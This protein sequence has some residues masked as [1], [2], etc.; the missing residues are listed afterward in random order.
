MP[1]LR[2]T[3]RPARTA[4]LY[5]LGSAFVLF[6][7]LYRLGDSPKLLHTSELQAKAAAK[8]SNVETNVLFAPWKLLENALLHL[9]HSVLAARLTSVIFGIICLAAFYYAMRAWLGSAIAALTTA[10]FLTTPVFLLSARHAT[11]AIMFFWPAVLIALYFYASRAE[12]GKSLVLLVA[13][14]CIGLYVPGLVWIAILGLIFGWRGLLERSREM[15]RKT[16]LLG[17]LLAII[18]LAPLIAGM[19]IH[20]HLIKPYLLLP[21]HF[22]HPL[23]ILKSWAWSVAALFVRARRHEELIL[24]RSSLFDV[25]LVAML[26]FGSYV[27]FS[28]LRLWF[29]LMISGTLLISFLSGL[30]SNFFALC[31]MVVPLLIVVGFGLRF[32]YLEWL[33]T[34]PNNPLPRYFAYGLMTALVI[35][36]AVY[37]LRYGLV[38]WPIA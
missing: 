24:G 19:V 33:H 25:A 16:I 5:G 30:S 20:P 12:T 35:I 36:H 32:L 28:K 38:A 4:V 2:R 6:C 22:A 11:P 10:L 37:G 3:W 9:N 15:E 27:L 18:L 1:R 26:L 21:D 8:L 14:V 23:E 34:F 7:M 29:Y 17:G 31:I 13:G